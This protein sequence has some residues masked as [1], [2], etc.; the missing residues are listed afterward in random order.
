M[1][2][3]S[4]KI[5]GKE[6]NK[7]IQHNQIISFCFVHFLKRLKI[8]LKPILKT[9]KIIKLPKTAIIINFSSNNIKKSHFYYLIIV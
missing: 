7:T 6:I 2:L 4:N 9:K 1:K 3:K 8:I 5:F